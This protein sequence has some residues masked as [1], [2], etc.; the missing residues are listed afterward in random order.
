MST[1]HPVYDSYG[2]YWPV[3]RVGAGLANVSGAINAKSYILMDEEA[4][5]FPDSARD[6]KVKAELGDD[7][8]HTGEYSFKF[9]LNPLEEIDADYNSRKR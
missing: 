6:G 4:T 2:D 8:E 3:F 5:M 9:T 7:P 1:A